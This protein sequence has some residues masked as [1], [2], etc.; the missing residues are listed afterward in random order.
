MGLYVPP[1]MRQLSFI[2]VVV[3][4]VIGLLIQF[5]GFLG[6]LIFDFVT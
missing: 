4:L 6:G 5:C 1:A 3:V 2:V